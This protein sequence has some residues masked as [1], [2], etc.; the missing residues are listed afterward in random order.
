[1]QI[2]SQ[3]SSVICRSYF[4][5]TSPSR[6][7][8]I[9]YFKF[10]R[11][12][13]P[14]K[15]Q[16]NCSRDDSAINTRQVTLSGCLSMFQRKKWKLVNSEVHPANGKRGRNSLRPLRSRV[17]PFSESKTREIVQGGNCAEERDG[18]R[19]RDK[20]NTG[21]ASTQ[22]PSLAS[23]FRRMPLFVLAWQARSTSATPSGRFSL[24]LAGFATSLVVPLS[25]SLSTSPA[26]PLGSLTV[27]PASPDIATTSFCLPDDTSYQISV[28][29][30]KYTVFALSPPTAIW[31]VNWSPLNIEGTRDE[32]RKTR[33]R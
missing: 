26:F 33:E 29:R 16:N 24:Y 19:E 7:I 21:L 32:P 14:R 15:N 30:L 22:F 9:I 5:Y 3:D 6:F 18:E 27:T 20:G 12:R 31:L 4:N 1:M 17:L 23:N 25:Q 2:I 28:A 11:T 13:I 8:S 10:H